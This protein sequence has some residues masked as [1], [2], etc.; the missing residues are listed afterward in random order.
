MTTYYA[1][2]LDGTITKQE[3]LPRIAAALGL[4]NEMRVLTGLTLDGTI[5]FEDS[6]R[7][8]CAILQSISISD[9]QDIV[10]DVPLDQDIVDFIKQHRETSF[11]VTGNLDVWIRPLLDLLGC[12][13]FSST[14]LCEGNRLVRLNHVLHK[15]KPIHHLKTRA[16]RVVAIGDSV[17]DI[18]MFEAADVGIAYGGV[19]DPSSGLTE[20]ADYLTYQ[21]SALCRLLNT[22]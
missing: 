17:N 6:F 21:G 18:P 1:F 12:S 3:L 15:S 22:L 2:D 10:A 19:H 8:R 20:I 11:V 7:L 9:V 4:Q 13:A 14:A 5:G 16:H